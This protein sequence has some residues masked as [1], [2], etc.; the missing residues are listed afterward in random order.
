MADPVLQISPNP[1]LI[2]PVPDPPVSK[3][4]VGYTETPDSLTTNG[5]TDQPLADSHPI[6]VSTPSGHVLAFDKTTPPEQV[7]AQTKDWWD[8]MTDAAYTAIGH[9][10]PQAATG[11]LKAGMD[12]YVNPT[13]KALKKVGDVAVASVQGPQYG[14]K[15]SAYLRSQGVNP[16]GPMPDWLKG[17]NDES[18]RFAA[19]TVADPRMWPFFGEK[20]ATEAPT[21][22]RQILNRAL[23]GTVASNASKDVVNSVRDLAKNWSKLSEKDR[24]AALTGG[25]LSAVMAGLSGY[26]S[27]MG[28]PVAEHPAE[29]TEPGPRVLHAQTDEP[30][31][32]PPEPGQAV[33]VAPEYSK[34]E[35]RVVP[36]TQLASTPETDS[37][38]TDQFTSG[39]TRKLK[40]GVPMDVV[41]QR[42]SLPSADYTTGSRK[43]RLDS[44]SMDAPDLGTKA[45]AASEATF[46]PL[47]RRSQSRPVTT[48]G[49][50][51]SAASQEAINRVASDKA[52]GVHTYRVDSRSGKPTP[53]LGV[54]AVD[55]VAGPHDHI[56]QIKGDQ[57]TPVDSGKSAKP[58]D[59]QSLMKQLADK[60]APL[61]PDG[62]P[63]WP[64]NYVQ[65]FL[66][67]TDKGGSNYSDADLQKLKKDLGLHSEEPAKSKSKAAGGPTAHAEPASDLK[68]RLA[69]RLTSALA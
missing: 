25:T 41:G 45:R 55:A 34:P 18:I 9:A 14:P 43:L 32:H 23:A 29:N 40:L 50:G 22:A 44:P 52:N 20:L 36:R 49:S 60:R 28:S 64:A 54:D 2:P 46:G 66:Q 33:V 1:G 26:H 35:P 38:P 3:E 27:A 12:Y 19:Q 69:A 15:T 8:R 39:G 37:S 47:E 31:A 53:L 6:Q 7:H 56:V 51:D 24:S 61:N 5:L 30:V 48:N 42:V 59:E 13:N 68:A 58:L 63:N 57:V 11:P 62:T 67:K 17:V 21:A 4:P 65:T 10:I 16:E